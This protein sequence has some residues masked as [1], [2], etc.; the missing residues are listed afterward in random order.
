MWS[1][2]MVTPEGELRS[3]SQSLF[4]SEVE[5]LS[6]LS[7]PNIVRCDRTCLPD[8]VL[9]LTYCVPAVSVQCRTL[10]ALWLHATQCSVLTHGKCLNRPSRA[11]RLGAGL[12]HALTTD[13]EP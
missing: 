1:R 7:H 4:Q 11:T 12:L 6:T 9:T 8:L 3:G 5:V 10:P 2:R 13:S